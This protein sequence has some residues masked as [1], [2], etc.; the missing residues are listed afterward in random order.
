MFTGLSVITAAH[1]T[2]KGGLVL[3]VEYPEYSKYWREVGAAYV[4]T[5]R[6][7]VTFSYIAV[8]YAYVRN[9]SAK[10]AGCSNG[11]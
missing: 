5:V 7:L 6:N 9:F 2:N 4:D 10:N 3:A 8:F 11:H 1:E